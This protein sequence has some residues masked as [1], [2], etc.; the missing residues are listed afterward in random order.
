M[1][2]DEFALTITDGT[3]TFYF[4][5]HPIRFILKENEPWFV[6]NDCGKALGI[7]QSRDSLAQFPDDEKDGAGITDAIGRPQKTI[8]L[9]LPGLMRMIFQSRKAEAEAFKRYVYHEVLPAIQK[10]GK[11]EKDPES[12][13][14]PAPVLTLADMLAIR[15]RD[16]EQLSL[17]ADSIRTELAHIEATMAGA[18]NDRDRLNS[19]L[20]DVNEKLRREYSI[21]QGVVLPLRELIKDHAWPVI[22]S[23]A[24]LETEVMRLAGTCALPQS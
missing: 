24:A 4:A 17:H 16:Y 3:G 8:V 21:M 14:P 9:S 11:Y 1:K 13:L 10:T 22:M 6:A 5:G 20:L 12:L 19:R 15:K 23:S 2:T 7:R 18:M